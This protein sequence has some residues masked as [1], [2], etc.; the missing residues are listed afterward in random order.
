MSAIQAS[1][2]P[3]VEWF[4]DDEGK[5][6]RDQ[7]ERRPAFQAMLKAVEAGLV[8]VVVVDR[9]DRFGVKDA[10]EW[11]KFIDFL[12]SHGAE[13]WDAKGNV[14]SADDDV[15]ILTGMLGAIT[16]VR[17]QKEKA[18]RN[19]SGKLP[20]AKAGEYQ[21]GYSP[22]GC[23]VVC[24]GPDGEEK[25]RTVYVGHFD[26]WKVYPDGTQ[27]RF[28][29]K[30]NIPAKDSHDVLKIRPSIKK[31]RLDVVRQI[32]AWYATESISPGQIAARLNDMGVDPVMGDFWNKVKIRNFL[33]N[34]AYIGLP[35]FNKNG[36]SRFVEYVDGRLREVAKVNGR[37]KLGRKRAKKD[38]IQPDKP[39]YPPIIDSA[40]WNTV[41]RKLDESSTRVNAIPKRAPNT[42]DLWLKPFLVCGHCGKPMRA[43]RGGTDQ[44]WP[45]YFCGTYGTYGKNNPF[46]C[47]CHRVRHEVLER[48]VLKYLDE[49]APAV[50]ELLETVQSGN[51]ELAAPLKGALRDLQASYYGLACDM[52]HFIDEH[53]GE[54]LRQQDTLSG[55]YAVVHER[56]VPKIEEAI[57]QKEAELDRMLAAY[58]DLPGNLKA[59]ARQSMEALQTEV[60]QLRSN[61]QDLS[62][63]FRDLEAE[64]VARR[65]TLDRAIAEMRRDRSGRQKAEAL[66][67]VVDKI[68]CFF[69]HTEP[70]V[71]SRYAGKSYLNAVEI[72]PV[73]NVAQEIAQE[74]G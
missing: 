50:R 43:T 63:P 37:V 20:R 39:E 9:Q 56:M 7:A 69:R 62:V 46:G 53:A 52:L 10:Y 27:E 16:S 70:K 59:R 54:E 23:D 28:L 3:I 18:H 47:R 17:E 31:E 30:D 4:R 57:E 25:W 48:I 11:G 71:K 32:F 13:L 60:D 24:F 29:G 65:D 5:N 1:G 49:T 8:N 61:L 19:L 35:T 21:G 42:S 45:S 22:Y 36:G 12:R 58:I 74:P 2:F 14:L 41:Q 40:T 33:K 73:A 44:A 68:V 26:R 64:L 66:A 72:T 6:P 51:L 38:F 67:G 34:P 55:L 15:S